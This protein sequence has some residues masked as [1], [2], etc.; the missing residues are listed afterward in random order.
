[1]IHSPCDAVRVH[2]SRLRSEELFAQVARERRA[3]QLRVPEDWGRNAR[4]VPV[5]RQ[6]VRLPAAIAGLRL[7]RGGPR[8]DYAPGERSAR[9]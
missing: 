7:R 9:A 3:Q 5:L 8:V 4:L 6:I 2:L 1:V